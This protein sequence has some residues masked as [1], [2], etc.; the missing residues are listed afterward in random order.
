MH[1]HSV[2]TTP[3]AAPS[4]STLQR[5]PAAAPCSS[6]LQW[7]NAH[8]T[9]TAARHPA[10]PGGHFNNSTLK[11]HPARHPAA[12]PIP[13]ARA[14]LCPQ[15]PE[16]APCSGTS[17]PAPKRTRHQH[18]PKSHTPLGQQHSE[19]APCRAP[20]SCAL[21]PYSG[22]QRH[23]AAACCSETNTPTL[24]AE[25]EAA[26]DNGIL[27]GT[28]MPAPKRTH[29]SNSSTLERHQKPAPKRTHHLTAAAE[30]LQSAHATLTAA[31]WAAPKKCK[32]PQ[33][34]EV[35]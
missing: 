4:S 1:L 20:C 16:A 21:A 23:A 2:H 13:K 17:T 25:L 15:H 34:I 31:P 24:T 5:H 9:L 12:A 28:T 3:V 27:H 8:T 6:V 22:M 11:Q 7:Q 14:P 29:H 10:A 30:Q 32:K 18:A 35:F 26:P 33:F 19:A